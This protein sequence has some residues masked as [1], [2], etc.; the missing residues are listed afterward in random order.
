LNTFA[1][2]I[3]ILTVP[4]KII[5]ATGIYPPKIGGPATYCRQLAERLSKQGHE[6]IVVTYGDKV[7]S[8]KWKV[9]TVP[10]GL[11]VLRWFSYAKKLKEAGSEA[12]VTYAF[13]SISCGIPLMLS[14][15]KSKK[16]LRLGGDFFWERYTDGSGYRGLRAWY[17]SKCPL[18]FIGRRVMGWILRR[19]DHIV[20]STDFQKD[21]YA[22]VFSRLP[23][24]SVIEN[25]LELEMVVP[26]EHHIMQKPFKLLFMGRFVNFK[27]IPLLID[28]AAQIPE[29]VL[30]LVGQG[31]RD[32]ALR[33]QVERLGLD[34]KIRFVAP[35]SGKE[36]YEV[37]GSHDLL[38]L[39]SLTD[40]SPNTALEARSVGLPVLL[41]DQNGLSPSL[42][43]GMSIADVSTVKKLVEEIK[44]IQ[45]G[46]SV[47]AESAS[48]KISGRSWEEVALETQNLFATLCAQ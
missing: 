10:L 2:S 7:E 33:K 9:E 6:V 21:I 46:Y 30:T 20:F 32:V 38:V 36:K 15:L 8:G 39:P 25:A 11:P 47:I 18:A 4:M 22:G 1:N 44:R 17:A 35:L 31:P 19:F 41:T 12:D 34:S 26:M 13:S 29:A 45:Q 48:Q 24:S 3:A 40:I 37:F 27:Q 16:V 23:S 28:A 5:L 43:S 14:G 42:H